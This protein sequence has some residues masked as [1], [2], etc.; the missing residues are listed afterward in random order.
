MKLI[1]A[2]LAGRNR[3][4]PKTALSV[5]QAAKIQKISN[6]TKEIAIKDIFECK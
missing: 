3:A 4:D 2:L 5:E 1:S 6:R